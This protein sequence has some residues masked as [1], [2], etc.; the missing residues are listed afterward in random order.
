MNRILAHTITSVAAIVAVGCSSQSAT[1]ST[2]LLIG[3]STDGESKGLYL[4]N[5]DLGS[6][7]ASPISMTELENPTFVAQD[8][9]TLFSVVENIAE[10]AAV[11][12]YNLDCESGKFEKISSRLV[13]GDYPCHILKGDGWVGTANYG[14]GSISLF[15]VASDGV[16]GDMR[17][18]IEFNRDGDDRAS[19]LHCLIPSPDGKI[20]FAT[21]LG[22]DSVYRF[23]VN[24]R[25]DILA[26]GSILEPQYPSISVAKGSGPRH[27]TFS[28]DGARAYLI[29]ELSGTIIAFD[30]DGVTLTEFQTILA[31]DRFGAGSADIHI[32]ADGGFLY[33]SHR[34][35]DDGISTFSIEPQ[36]G[37]LTKIDHIDSGIHPRN[38]TLSP[39][40]KLL[41][42]A[43]R[44]SDRVQIFARDELSGKLTY[45]GAEYDIEIDMPMFVKF[46]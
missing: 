46:L 1:T 25:E 38:F 45:L 14:G 13:E 29:N 12:S 21:D 39:D 36:T 41:L 23:R 22:M 20:L 40:G 19:H 2:R 33:A 37:R 18:H 28:P 3:T 27:M 9:S 6:Y 5:F 16:M 42:V 30:Y 35:K 32:S 10:S 8:G 4:Y 34:L 31:D 43:C 44:D 17:Q 24:S 11:V 7:K 15:A 26:G